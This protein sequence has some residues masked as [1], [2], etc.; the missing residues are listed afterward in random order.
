V[1]KDNILIHGIGVQEQRQGAPAALVLVEFEQWLGDAPLVG[2]H[3]LFDV[4]MLSRA[5]NDHQGRWLTHP[6]L[7]LEP[8]AAVLH[9]DPT[10]RDLDF[11]LER[12]GIVCSQRHR[13]IADAWATAELLQALWP[14]LKLQRATTWRAMQKLSAQ[15]RWLVG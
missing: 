4:T 8:L 13:A 1:D 6:W 5:L 2:F 14:K 3:T 7:D 15:R 10:P 9:G 12:F 11:W